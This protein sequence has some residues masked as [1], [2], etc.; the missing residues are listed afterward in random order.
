[1]YNIKTMKNVKSP[2]IVNILIAA[3]FVFDI[4]YRITANS[5][6]LYTLFLISICILLYLLYKGKIKF[7]HIIIV[8]LINV[9]MIISNIVSEN[10]DIVGTI[11]N[12]QY[13][14]IAIAISELKISSRLLAI[15]YYGV[16][17]FFFYKMILG[18]DPNVVFKTGSRNHLITVL[19]NLITI[20]S[21]SRY[22]ENKSVQIISFLLLIVISVWSQSR[23]SIMVSSFLF[24]LII[25]YKIF[26]ETRTSI[27]KKKIEL[28]K[29][30]AVVLMIGILVILQYEQISKFIESFLTGSQALKK[31]LTSEGFSDSIR[32]EIISNY[33]S[34]VNKNP[35]YF[36][37]G[38]SIYDNNFFSVVDFN[39]H[40]SY[41]TLHAY[42]GL[43][44]MLFVLSLLI[45]A[46]FKM[47][48]NKKFLYL[49]LIFAIMIRIFTDIIAL[50]GYLDI[51]LYVFIFD[52][53][54]SNRKG[55]IK[56]EKSINNRN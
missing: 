35:L 24:F 3:Y 41:L 47:I 4:F 39:L 19:L 13:I 44:G 2:Y 11:Y 42:H 45:V 51:S 27:K 28:Y 10:L 50:P 21:I 20:Y 53:V 25:I 5:L 52:A 55:E 8:S 7:R 33:F 16:I 49:A 26:L 48:R 43:F 54:S 14:I 56:N 9:M 40:N 46:I 36:L 12:L 1:M 29:Y 34:L 30:V 23:V 15:V 38:V 32:E 31:R 22:K 6:L 37:F 17:I 18:I